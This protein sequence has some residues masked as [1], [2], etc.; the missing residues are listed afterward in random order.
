MVMSLAFVISALIQFALG[1]V[2]AS[3]LGP[4]LF[5]VHALG[6]AAAV[7]GQT[8]AFEWIRLSITRFYHDG[9]DPAFKAKLEKAGMLLAA[10][11]VLLS[12]LAFILGGEQRVV[13]AMLPL[14]ALGAG[15]ADYRAA[16]L[17]ATFRQRDYAGLTVLRNLTAIVMLPLAAWWFQSAE[18]TLAALALSTLIA[19]A[20]HTMLSK[21]S[22][23]T[24]EESIAHSPDWSGI[25]R[26]SGPIILTNFT[27]LLLFF[28][29]RS[30]VAF[31]SG[32]A[33]A[34]QFSLALEFA[35]KLVM[36]FGTALDLFL[37][38]VAVRES[39]S[40]SFEIARQ[41]VRANAD[42]ILALLLPMVLGLWLILPSIE[43]LM[44]APAFREAFSAHLTLLLPGIAVFGI[45][46]YVLHPFF[47]LDGRTVPLALAGLLAV[48][49]A[50]IVLAAS[51]NSVISEGSA[52]GLASAL[53]M[54]TAASVLLARIG[55]P[56]REPM[57]TSLRLGVALLAMLAVT[58]PLR[59]LT[60]G[61]FVGSTTVIVG[62]L[63]Y[64]GVAYALNLAGLRT[65]LRQRQLPQL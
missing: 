47:Q 37:F 55:N 15:Y 13:Y 21:H 30:F 54:L 17:R 18:A 31:Q 27:Y 49:L 1:L 62:S 19:T 59:A 12:V 9:Q 11:A 34:G 32:M 22:A 23:P 63:V 39:R 29:L 10:G 48:M 40:G 58:L 42:L 4:A 56:L 2:I 20:C 53:A 33:A 57:K 43:V 8:L 61:F 41:R 51:R 46:Q 16:I 24:L 45:I 35:L 44:I 36:T 38:Q 50:L 3:M 28:A 7:L 6:V 60:A 64:F 5:G 65:I 52:V 25:L 14:V 26:Y